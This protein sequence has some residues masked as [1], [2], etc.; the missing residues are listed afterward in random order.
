[1]VDPEL[2]FNSY[3]ERFDLSALIGFSNLLENRINYPVGLVDF[4]AI[5]PGFQMEILSKETL[6]FSKNEKIRTDLI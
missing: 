1:M 6:L 5:S 3:K 2:K 4:Q